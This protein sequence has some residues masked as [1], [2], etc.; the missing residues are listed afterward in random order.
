MP[1]PQFH[2]TPKMRKRRTRR[3]SMAPEIFDAPDAE[4]EVDAENESPAALGD[5]ENCALLQPGAADDRNPAPP[6]GVP[7]LLSWWPP[8]RS[9]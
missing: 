3:G 2:R 5:G 9:K 4:A 8:R 1:I 7:A 6:E